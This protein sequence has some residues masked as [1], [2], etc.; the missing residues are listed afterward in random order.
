MMRPAVPRPSAALWPSLLAALL[1]AGCNEPG[2]PPEPPLGE[3]ALTAVAVEPGVPREAL[4]RAVD[5]LFTREGLGKTH[6]LVLMHDGA[7]AAERYGEGFDEETRHRGKG[8]SQA[9]M[10]VLI[11]Q[12][13][14][15]GRVAL[16]EVPPIPRWQRA[17]D[18]HG[19][20]TLRHLLQMRSGIRHQQGVEPAHLSAEFRM[21]YLDGRDD[22]AGW[23]EVQPLEHEPGR[24]FDYS[25]PTSMILADIAARLLAPGGTAE[26]RQ[27][28]LAHFLDA[29]LAA[30]LS[31]HSMVAEFDAA[32]TMEGGSGI[33]ASARDWARFGELLRTGGSVAG[34]QV[35]QRGWVTFMRSPSPA[36]PDFGAHLWLNHDSGTGRDM[37]LGGEG[38]RGL[39]AAIGEEGQFV[40]V[41]PD[42]RLTLVRLGRSGEG[43]RQALIEAL[44]QIIA[45]YPQR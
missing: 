43:E 31:I 29:R 27:A 2:P 24:V 13:V 22:M 34:V 14:G 26:E 28:A 12:M 4:A 8:L 35:V 37:L 17:G 33:W 9:V 44:A 41:S 10:G 5:A 3:S 20:I 11:G 21:Q 45:L 1:L 25:T 18:P 36:S 39:F 16:D 42:Q 38:P 40:L 32:G 30:P 6:A 23:A 7:I 19:A 15:D